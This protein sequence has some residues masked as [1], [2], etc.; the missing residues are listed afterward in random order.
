MTKLQ[1]IAVLSIFPFILIVVILSFNDYIGI[2]GYWIISG[3]YIFII[4]ILALIDIFF[5]NE[6][7]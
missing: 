1:K 5:I 7:A 2:K 4:F 6:D 3:I